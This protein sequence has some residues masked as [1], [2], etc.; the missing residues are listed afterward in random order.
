MYAVIIHLFWYCVRKEKKVNFVPCFFHLLNKWCKRRT[1]NDWGCERLQWFLGACC[2]C[3]VQSRGKIPM[4]FTSCSYISSLVVLWI[5][6]PAEFLICLCELLS[7]SFFNLSSYLLPQS[8]IASL[9]QSST[10]SAYVCLIYH[11][12]ST[13][14][15]YSVYSK[16]YT[17]L[18]HLQ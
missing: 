18:L 14:I 3:H 6:H 17:L 2:D 13:N 12:N 10:D 4:H 7:F 9:P 16:H 5:S 11:G 8:I 1:R 15:F